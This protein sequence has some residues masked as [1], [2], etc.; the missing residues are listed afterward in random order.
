MR[1]ANSRKIEVTSV[2]YDKGILLQKLHVKAKKPMPLN[3]KLAEK[4]SKLYEPSSRI[5][6][7]FRG[8]D[9]TFI[10][11]EHGE[12]VTLFI[13]K[14]REDGAIAGERYVRVI[15]KRTE[16]GAIELSHWENK[17]K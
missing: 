12:P 6:D 3:P 4:L 13:G 16:N 7:H 17:G 8:N 10:T 2:A 5:D 9:L 1:V 15:K 11:N 14:R